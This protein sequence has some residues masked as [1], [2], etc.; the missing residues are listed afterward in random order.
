[1]K[2]LAIAAGLAL[3]G[4]AACTQVD[5]GPQAAA[6]PARRVALAA[7]HVEP[8]SVVYRASGTVRGR[9]TTELTSKTAGYVRAVRVRSGDSVA[10]GQTLVELEANDTRASVARARALLAQSEEAKVEA[11]GGLEAARAAAKVAKSSYERARELLAKTAIPEQ[12]FDEAEARWQG[13]QALEYAAEARV[14]TVGSRIAEAKAGVAETSAALGYATIEAPFSGRVL[15]RRVDP[16]ALATPGTPLLVI[17]DEGMLRVEAA[18]EESRANAVAVGDTADIEIETLA[19]PIVGKVA[20]IVPNVDVASRA[21]L[22][23]LDLPRETGTLR[24]GAFARV[25]FHVGTRPRLVVPTT[26]LTPFGALDR[27]F[28]ADGARAR[29]RMVTLGEAQGPWTGVLSGL[30]EGERVLTSPPSDLR[31]GALIEARP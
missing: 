27:V 29:L 22:V 16:G 19:H 25:G 24:P 1:M 6:Q 14:R 4:T 11:E 12:Q 28:V 9:S 8:L 30:S 21:F 10:A 3:A 15:E 23:K 18:V 5:S 17:A 20:E 31:D 26:A 7:A 13:A 2:P